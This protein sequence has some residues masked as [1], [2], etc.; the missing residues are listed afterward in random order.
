MKCSWAPL[1]FALWIVADLL[2]SCLC[3]LDATN[4]LHALDEK[5]FKDFL[6]RK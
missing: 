3:F 4:E 5:M 6:L 1:S 2:C